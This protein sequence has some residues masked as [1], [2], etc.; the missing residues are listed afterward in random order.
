MYATPSYSASAPY[1]YPTIATVTQYQMETKMPDQYS[2][3]ESEEP[4]PIES[5]ASCKSS[6]TKSASDVAIHLNAIIHINAIAADDEPDCE[7]TT[8]PAYKASPTSACASSSA[9]TPT[10]APVHASYSPS[11]PAGYYAMN[12]YF[13]GKTPTTIAAEDINDADSDDEHTIL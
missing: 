4:S 7:S 3:S 5:S 10:P 12:Y 13:V 1:S 8:E 2:T 6:A 9:P 11:N